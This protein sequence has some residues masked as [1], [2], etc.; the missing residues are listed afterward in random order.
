ML[1]GFNIFLSNSER[2]IKFAPGKDYVINKN[3]YIIDKQNG[4]GGA[5]KKYGWR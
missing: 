4:I 2:I 5:G 3:V 1:L